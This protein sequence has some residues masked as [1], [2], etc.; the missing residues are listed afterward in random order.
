MEIVVPD[1]YKYLYVQNDERPV[2]K[3]PDAVLRGKAAEVSKIGK[4]QQEL[5]DEM[6]RV[7]KLA[8]GI[9]LAAPQV[10]VLQRVILIATHDMRPVALLNPK[11][12]KSEGEQI[13]QEGCL[14]IPGLYGD[15]KRAK[16]V[17]LEAY[18][19]RGRQVEVELEDLAARVALHEIDH[20]E[21]V[22][23]TDKVDVATLYW[24]HPDQ[25]NN[26]DDE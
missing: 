15:V 1:E 9:G 26:D 8:N 25:N 2:V 23:F 14:S 21:G 16:Y 3:I 18:D 24:Q 12:L 22:L 5:I 17:K 20:L 11:V 10:G 13:G 6:F 19:R 4:K 7:L